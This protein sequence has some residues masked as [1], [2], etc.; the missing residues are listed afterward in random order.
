MAKKADIGSKKFSEMLTPLSSKPHKIII[1]KLDSKMFPLDQNKVFA[2]KTEQLAFK[3]Y[4]RCLS[5]FERRN[6]KIQP[7]EALLRLPGVQSLIIK[8][9]ETNKNKLQQLAIDTIKEIYQVPD[10]INIKALINPRL[11]LDTE[12]D[13]NKESFL[14]LTL[15]QKNK[16]LD[17]IKKRQILNSFAH[18]SSLTIW[19]GVYH[20]VNEELK[21]IDHS[22]IEL[23]D[24]YTSTIGIGIWM[25]NPDSFQDAIEEGNQITQGY[26]KLKFNRTQGFGGTIEAKG[27][28]FP[29]LLHEINKGVVDWLI[30]AG[31]PKEY[32][33]EELKYY[34]SKADDYKTEVFQ[35][36][37]SPSVWSELLD[38][39]QLD[40]NKIP[41][42]IS[43]LTKQNYETI[44]ELFRL[45]QDNKELATKKIQ[46]WKL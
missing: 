43:Y 38:A 32:T 20:L 6:K 7:E 14:S 27:I 46:G 42:L 30:S 12:Q 11:S 35:Y 28:N 5:L 8:A 4:S 16:M 10:Y 3:E 26:N 15:C 19:S 34:Y 1:K 29:V 37:L 44:V 39:A 45:I 22:L 21:K 13:T 33:E 23:Y 18:G 41:H 24:Y 36:L 40:N 2:Y 25:M 31:I 9:E 17:Q